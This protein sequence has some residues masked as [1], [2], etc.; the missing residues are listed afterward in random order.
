M[1]TLTVD[2]DRSPVREANRTLR[3]LTDGASVRLANPMGR[4][5]LAVGLDADVTVTIDGAAGYYAGGLGKRATVIVNGPAGWGAGEN[6][7][8]G[9][10]HVK[11]D[12]SQS[13]ASCAHG[14]TVVVDGDASLRAA[15]SLKGGTLAVGGDVGPYCAFLAQ[16]GTVLIGGDAGAHL[17]DSLYEAVIYVAGKIRSLGTDARVEELTETDV[18]RVRELAARCGFDH[19]DAENVTRV[20]SARQLYHFDTHAHDAY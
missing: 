11:G 4:H 5:N 1:D 13:A 3:E 16:A 12:A 9:L 14:G 6:L 20:A 19:I 8:S 10:V 18:A 2:L 17:G 7:M 15:I